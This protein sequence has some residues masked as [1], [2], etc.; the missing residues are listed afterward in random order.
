MYTR[1]ITP[2][3]DSPIRNGSPVFGSFAGPVDTFD[4]RGVRRPF[5]DLPI[6][7][8]LTNVRIMGTLRLLFCDGGNVGEIEFFDA[9]YFSFMETTLW[10]RDTKRRIAYRRLIPPG[11][12]KMP[13][14]LDNA[15]I[16]CRSRSR[17]VRIHSRLAKGFVYA[18]F[19]FLGSDYRPPCEGRLEMD[20]DVR[21]FADL[22]AVLP[23]S[24][25][26]RCQLSYQATAPLEGWISTG[27]DDQR[28]LADSGVGFLDVRTAYYPLRTKSS[29]LVGLGYLDGRLVSFQ[30][31]N[32][33]CRDDGRYNDNVL[34]V[35]GKAWPMPPVKVTRPYGIS[36][37]WI[38][39]DTESM[40]D[41]VFSPVSD[42]ARK[43]SA[44]VVR[45]DYHTVYGLF[46]GILLTGDGERIVLH[47]FPGVGKKILLRI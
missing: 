27:Y 37:E 32:S 28:I 39:Q 16:A 15:V 26:R 6:P 34:F 44:F 35:D 17:F 12:M 3:P 30:L 2:A 9:G 38:V 21:G 43:L 36:G 20:M 33:V 22:S 31:G 1:E 47:G 7:S 29:R 10:N 8:F 23:F 13:T 25:K 24:V 11:I 14:R 46:E 45:T 41:L 18:D 5:G 42:S 40:V 19:D 4:I